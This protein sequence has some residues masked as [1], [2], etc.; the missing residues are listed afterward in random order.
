M[1]GPR[2][3]HRHRTGQ[4]GAIMEQYPPM[5]GE[6]TGQRRVGME[7]SYHQGSISHNWIDLWGFLFQLFPNKTPKMGGIYLG[8]P[9][10]PPIVGIGVSHPRSGVRTC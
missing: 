6:E 7:P 2:A 1:Q 4:P 9:A 5:Q 3:W 8:F 10:P